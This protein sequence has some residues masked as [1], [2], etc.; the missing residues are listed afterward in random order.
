MRLGERDPAVGE[1]DPI[2]VGHVAATQP[3]SPDDVGAERVA[4]HGRE[5]RVVLVVLIARHVRT[6]AQIAD[7]AARPAPTEPSA[8]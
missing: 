5:R 4:E 8:V 6:L 3:G 7:S 1:F 2:R